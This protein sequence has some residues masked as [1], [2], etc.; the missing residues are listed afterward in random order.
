M[1]THTTVDSP[2]GPLTLV[3]DDG[4]LCGL[5]LAEHRRAP[6][7]AT[8]GPA[9][10]AGF[11]ALTEALAGYFAGQV[12]SFDDVPVAAAGTP[13]QQRVWTALREI[14]YGT[15]ATYGELAAAL[16]SPG[17]SRAVGAANARNPVSIVVP[18]HRVVGAGGAITGYAGGLARKRALL[19][20]EAGHPALALA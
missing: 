16:G 10:P 8:H 9:D 6:D 11:E 14:P 20:L 1:R 4:V 7:P 5:Y 17:A 12:E 18:C 13:F 2:I 3:A 15:T 19:D